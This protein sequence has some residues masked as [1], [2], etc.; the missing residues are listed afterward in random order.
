MILHRC[1]AIVVKRSER[2]LNRF[3]Q[4]AAQSQF[5]V[6]ILE[7]PGLTIGDLVVEGVDVLR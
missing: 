5:D 1:E 7:D 6:R 2:L 4:V 3:E